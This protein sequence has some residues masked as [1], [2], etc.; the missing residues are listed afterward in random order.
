MHVQVRAG[1]LDHDMSRFN[2]SEKQRTDVVSKP[3]TSF[4]NHYRAK[5]GGKPSLATAFRAG[6]AWGRASAE[7][8]AKA[9]ELSEKNKK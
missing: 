7:A 5:F 9:R 8:E 6:E 4:M 2:Q 1:N 3:F